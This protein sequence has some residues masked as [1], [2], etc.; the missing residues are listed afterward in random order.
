[1]KTPFGHLFGASLRCPLVGVWELEGWWALRSAKVQVLRK[2]VDVNAQHLQH[3]LNSSCAGLAR[4]LFFHSLLLLR[5][6]FGKPTEAACLTALPCNEYLIHALL[7]RIAKQA[8]QVRNAIEPIE[9][10][11]YA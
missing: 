5:Y 6:F 2:K 7:V 1:M 3:F 8:K 4:A 10:Q 9:Y 11:V